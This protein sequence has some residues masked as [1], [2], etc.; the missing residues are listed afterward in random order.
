[1]KILH[2]HSGN[3]YGGVEAILMTLVRY[4]YLCPEMDSHFALCFEERL[5]QEL[6]SA[7]APVYQLG[8]VRVRHLN[9]VWKARQALRNLLRREHFDLAVCHS[10]W[11]QGVFGP[12]IRAANKPMVYWMHNRTEGRHWT[13]RWARRIAPDQMLCV[14]LSTAETADRLYPQAPKEVF[15]SPLPF[16]ES[17]YANSEYAEIRAGLGIPLDATVI[18][19][20]S[21]MEAWKG[22]QLHLEALARLRHVP[23]WVCL[24]VGGAERPEEAVYFNELKRSAIRLGIVDRVKFLGRRPDVPRL[25]RAADIFCQPNRSTEGFSIVFMEAFLAGLPVVTTPIGGAV[26]IIDESCGVLVP[27]DDPDTLSLTLKHL[28]ENPALC[29]SLG[30]NGQA[31]VRKMCDPAR[32]MMKLGQIFSRVISRRQA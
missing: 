24:Q 20:V 29:A 14:S 13:E 9:S 30:T 3:L 11:T 25:L 23:G 10:A 6:R 4:G 22:H 12:V 1:M 27:L 16:I 2:V 32:Q 19:Q 26:E 31:R 28:V 17:N 5:G 8:N 15:Y 7:G 21:R 18:I